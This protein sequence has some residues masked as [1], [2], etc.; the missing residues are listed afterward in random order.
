MP[1][2]QKLVKNPHETD[3]CLELLPLLQ[4]CAVLKEN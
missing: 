2:I 4:G 3:A 1:K